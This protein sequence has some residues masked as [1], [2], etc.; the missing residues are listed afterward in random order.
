MRARLLLPA[1]LIASLAVASCGD[2]SE[3][4]SGDKLRVVAST[5]QAADFARA[6]GG[7]RV[8]VTQLLQP[9]SDPH[10]YEPRPSD[11]RKMA[12]ARLVLESGAG[13]D[14]WLDDAVRS[15]GGK[16]IVVDLSATVPVR[17]EGGEHSH[18]AD[19]PAE[20]EH[21]GEEEKDHAEEEKDHAEEEHA[22]ESE[23]DP[24]WWHDPRN[25]K[26]AVT[27]IR[28]SFAK[29]DPENAEAYRNAADAYLAKLDTLDRGIEQC[30]AA[31]PASERKL[32]TDHDAFI[33]FTERYDIDVV[34]AVFPSQTTQAQPN[35]RDIGRL[36]KLIK[37][38]DVRA[39]FPQDS[40]NTKAADALAKQTGA[41]TEHKL[42][43]D[44]L[45]PPESPA[46]TYLTMQQANADAMV[47]GFTVGRAG[48]QVD[49]I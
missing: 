27:A 10:D 43:G 20:E 21:A 48:C 23:T 15:S 33:Y 28:D 19:E 32:V 44:T 41:T 3:T 4:T 31:V 6:V 47:R 34:G 24:H 8:D 11:V 42:Y 1:A 9:N 30:L 29:A 37:R 26:A 49:G 39:I 25:A 2:D 16:P 38:E 18:G 14:A 13:L 5:T 17:H 22:G 40:L 7:D 35:A 36:A 12:E 45:G 46:G